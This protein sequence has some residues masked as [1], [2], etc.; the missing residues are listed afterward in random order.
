MTCAASHAA[1]QTVD[2]PPFS[3][4]RGPRPGQ[5]GL[6]QRVLARHRA[7][8]IERQSPLIVA[9]SG[10]TDSLALAAALARLRPSLGRAVLAVHVDHALRPESGAE[11]ERAVLLARQI[12]LSIVVERLDSGLLVRHPGVGL[13]EAARRER[14]LVLARRAAEV[15]AQ[16]VAVAHQRDDQ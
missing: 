13:E 9:F 2:A 12:D 14:Y 16:T 11:A 7:L 15:G 5:I 4:N 8:P 3:V 1:G 6:E 10:G